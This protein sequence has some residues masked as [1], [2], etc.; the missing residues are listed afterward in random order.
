MLLK[1]KG[2]GIDPNVYLIAIGLLL[3]LLAATVSVYLLLE[4]PRLPAAE[5]EPRGNIDANIPIPTGGIDVERPTGEQI[6]D[7]ATLD[8]S[9]RELPVEMSAVEIA[10]SLGVPYEDISG[11]GTDYRT[12]YYKVGV[13]QNGTYAASPVIVALAPCATLCFGPNQMHLIMDYTNHRLLNLSAYGLP[14]SQTIVL[15]N[16]LGPGQDAVVPPGRHAVDAPDIRL[17]G[18]DAPQRITVDGSNV[19]LTLSEIQP[20]RFV[21]T[22]ETIEIGRTTDG[23]TLYSMAGTGCLLI[24]MPDGIYVQYD[25]PLPFMIENRIPQITWDDGASNYA[26]YSFADIGGCGVLNCYAVREDAVLR[27]A[28]RLIATGQTA[29]GDTVYAFKDARDEEQVRV[30]DDGTQYVPEDQKK[31]TYEEFLAKHPVFFWKD[32]LGRWIRFVRQDVLPAVEC[33]KPVIYLYPEKQMS[34][35]VRVGLKGEMTVSEPP[36]GTRGWKVTARPDGYVVNAADGK[37]YPNLFWEGTGVNYRTPQE[38]FV[39]KTAEADAWLTKTLGA[40]GFT[41]RESAEFREFWVPRLPTTPHTFITFVPQGDFDRDAPLFISPRPDR[42]YRVFM[43]TRGL[44]APISVT[45]LTLPKIERK[46]FTVVEWGGALR[47]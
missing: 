14:V 46:G 21:L 18:L 15:P 42:V 30:Y 20:P 4:R 11:Q 32:R 28:A 1:K 2:K 47:K 23:R 45:P 36:H 43:E 16:E 35:A 3:A 41:E 7:T 6:L 5:E 34:V 40:I 26:D 12:S 44:Q 19:V 8:V 10:T 31:P 9:W 17:K 38:G 39:I 22:A 33:G 27:P 24:R 25:M 37:T 29:T 13:V